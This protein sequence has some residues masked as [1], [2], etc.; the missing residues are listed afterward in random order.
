MVL[1]MSSPS[2]SLSQQSEKSQALSFCEQRSDQVKIYN[3]AKYYGT[4]MMSQ[5][6]VPI[7][8]LKSSDKHPV[9]YYQQFFGNFY[10][11]N[12][13]SYVDSDQISRS[14]FNNLCHP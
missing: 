14:V 10:L 2:P 12:E 13:N 9:I 6:K 7:Y 5:F 3:N 11:E 8:S 1:M 4:N